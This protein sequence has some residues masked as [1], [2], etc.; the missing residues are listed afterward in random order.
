[1]TLTEAAC[2]MGLWFLASIPAALIWG[3]VMRHIAG[4]Y[5]DAE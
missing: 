1:M 4:A 3:R 2:F 5:H